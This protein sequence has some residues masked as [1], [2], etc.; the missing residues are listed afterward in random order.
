MAKLLR[1]ADVSPMA[2]LQC[3]FAV[4][5]DNV[6][7]VFEHLALHGTTRHGYEA[8]EASTPEMLSLLRSRIREVSSEPLATDLGPFRW[9]GDTEW[10]LFSDGDASSADQCCFAVQTDEAEEIIEHAKSHAKRRHDLSEERVTPETI[11]LWRSR[12]HLGRSSRLS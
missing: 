1:C 6:E 2:A 5:G 7:E 11:A 9:E 4:R 3:P 12:I 10:K 8:D